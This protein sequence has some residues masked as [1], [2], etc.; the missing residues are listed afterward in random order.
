MLLLAADQTLLMLRTI[1]YCQLKFLLSYVVESTDLK[2]GLIKLKV[3]TEVDYT[4][5]FILQL[6]SRIRTN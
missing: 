5:N 1:C 6:N 3:T 4:M 2:S